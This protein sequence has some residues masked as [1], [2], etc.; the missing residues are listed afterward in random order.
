L[1]LVAD[2]QRPGFVLAAGDRQN[3]LPPAHHP[4]GL[5]EEPMPTE[6]HAVASVIDGLGYA[7]DLGVGLED[8]R[9]DIRAPQQFQCRRQP[10]RT[11]SRN[12]GDFGHG[13]LKG[14]KALR[15]ESGDAQ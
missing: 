13:S 15:K 4:V 3:F 10:G 11:G 12:H 14:S 5:R 1:P 9:R 8:D 2:A 7:A 6:I